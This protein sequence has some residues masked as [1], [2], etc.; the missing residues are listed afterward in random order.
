[1]R[2]ILKDNEVSLDI[3]E[4]LSALYT[5]RVKYRMKKLSQIGDFALG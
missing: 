1:M 3:P 4:D 2:L 5:P